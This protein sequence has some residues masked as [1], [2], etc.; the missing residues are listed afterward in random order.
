[1]AS[2]IA[3]IKAWMRS[4]QGQQARA[5]AERMARDPR[6]KAKARGLLTKFRGKRH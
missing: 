6:T 5:R 1:M 4:P 3:K 2:L